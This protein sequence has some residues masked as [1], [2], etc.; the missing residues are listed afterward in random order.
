MIKIHV[1]YRWK[2]LLPILI[3]STMS[4]LPVIGQDR[5]SATVNMQ[6]QLA[7]DPAVTIGKLSNGFSYYI[8]S[9]KE[10]K[11]KVVMYLVNKVGS[12]LENDNQQ[13]LAHLLEHMSFNGTT[14]FP[15][16]TMV[17]FLEKTGVRFGADLNA[18][19]SF[20]ETVYQLPFPIENPQM[21]EKGL[22][23]MRDWAREATL[24][25]VE[26]DKERGVVLE[27]K[28]LAEGT[29]KRISDLIFPMMV[30]GSRYALRNPIG[31]EQVIKNFPPQAIK[32]FYRDW[33]RPNLQALIVVGD[34]DV[35]AVQLMVERLFADLKNP[36]NQRPR[37]EYAIELKGKNQY[38]AIA[39][40]EIPV[41]SI[42]VT[43]KHYRQHL[44]TT[45][46]Y[47]DLVV[48]G[49]FNQMTAARFAAVA[50]KNTELYLRAG[51][52]IGS[53]I[54]NMD[55]FSGSVSVRPG[56]L[57]Q[58]FRTFW[59][60]ILSIRNLGF[61]AAELE[62]AKQNY[63]SG[64]ER[65]LNEKDHKSSAEYV[66]EYTRH[67]TIGEASPGIEKEFELTK[68]FLAEIDLSSVKQLAADFIT[69][70][71]RDVVVTA[72]ASEQANLPTE[73]LMNAW[74]DSLEQ[75]QAVLFKEEDT[76][77]LPLM[78][79][80]PVPGRVLSEKSIPALGIT[81]LKFS[82]GVRVIL[83]PT[84]FKS[85]E[86]NFTAFSPGGTSLYPFADDQSGAAAAGV[87]AAGGIGILTPAQLR[88]TLNGKQLSVSPYIGESLEGVSGGA[89]GKDLETALQ[90][91]YLY[92]TQPRKDTLVFANSMSRAKASLLNRAKSPESEFSDTINAVMN[93]YH[94]RRTAPGVDKLDRIDLARAME[95]YKDRFM[96]ASDFTFIFTGSFDPVAVRPLLL[97]YLGGLPATGRKESAK[98]LGIRMPK[99]QLSRTVYN[100][101]AEKATV[102]LVIHGDYQF[103]ERNNL[104]LEALKSIL[105]FRLTDRLREQEGGVYSPSVGLEL[106]RSPQVHYSFTVNFGCSPQNV[107]K[108]IA[109][110]WEEIDKL[111]DQGVL[112]DDLEK[113]V[114]EETVAMKAVM[115]SNSF[116]TNY[117]STQYQHNDS[118]EKV[119]KYVE[120]LKRLSVILL[121][122][123]AQK[124]LGKQNYMRFVL[125][126]AEIK[127]NK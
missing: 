105:G 44:S 26:I 4:A 59:T 77:L 126:P 119:L 37:P 60:E 122:K 51:A 61:T 94:M 93:N 11:N 8:R 19:T 64:M 95:I 114:A 48:R 101:A 71:N 54:A 121:Q 7:L 100:G 29:K 68:K 6:E 3:V 83:K 13:G 103:S 120:Q 25:P 9:N 85:D 52:G 75:A 92:F 24:D 81:N 79:S 86:I 20:D 116:W 82:N 112:A 53:F 47:R 70:V 123:T 98:D 49:L 115:E 16:K 56:Q 80:V 65:A 55:S 96:D 104:Q 38:I 58:G 113:F 124:Y 43:I 18:Y 66:Q 109:A 15:G 91:V 62:R 35:K 28:R 110:T 39:D 5:V 84:K 17:N 63:L 106:T 102:K 42:E 87:V 46:G 31:T 125:L 21:L 45:G 69:D 41:A 34:V 117:L 57:E 67:F 12:I 36:V 72:P 118:P 50:E 22:Q 33:Y 32:D 2:H 10:P 23:V 89:T 99:G 73:Q 40:P 127:L 107:D 30:N 76:A 14:N 97:K 90:L 74:F 78:T 1:K 27:E 108:L 88:R 111:R